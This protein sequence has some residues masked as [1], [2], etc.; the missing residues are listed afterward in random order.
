MSA[1]P[2]EHALQVKQTTWS[3]ARG[4]A[5]NSLPAFLRNKIAQ[6]VA[7]ILQVRE[8]SP[9]LPADPPD[10]RSQLGV[11]VPHSSS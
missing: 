6:N 7:C 5:Q 9:L 10:C 4:A 11:M 1:T 8:P 2:C 3:W